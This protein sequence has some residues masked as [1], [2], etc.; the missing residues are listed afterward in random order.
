MNTAIW[1]V[2]ALLAFAF[3]G[4]GAMKLTK[5][6]DELLGIGMGY[7]EDLS[8]GTLTFIGFAEL[9]G[10]IGPV[11]PPLTGVLPVLAPV[12]A[13]CL[14]LVMV[15]AAGVH[16]R[17]GELPMVAM[18]AMLLLLAAVVVWGRLVAVPL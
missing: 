7:A 3:A 2:Q 12:A 4:A 8:G 10:A 18:N 6:R 11:A 16:V 9:L 15:L 13:A 17:R 5:S 14:G 1:I